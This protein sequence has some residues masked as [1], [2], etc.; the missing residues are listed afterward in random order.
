MNEDGLPAGCFPCVSQLK[1]NQTLRCGT[2]AHPEHSCADQKAHGPQ[3]VQVEKEFRVRLA[4]RA[5]WLAAFTSLRHLTS[6]QVFGFMDSLR[7]GTV[8]PAA[9]DNGHI[10]AWTGQA[11]VLRWSVTCMRRNPARTKTNMPSA[12]PADVPP[13]NWRLVYAVCLPSI[14]WDVCVV[15]SP[16]ATRPPTVPSNSHGTEAETRSRRRRFSGKETVARLGQGSKL[17]TW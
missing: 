11:V 3:Q 1:L 17:H 10:L 9:W 4:G 12:S 2:G 8:P 16:P 15:T 14:S 7:R 13:D 6:Q 5:L